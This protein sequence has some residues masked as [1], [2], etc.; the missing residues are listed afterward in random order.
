MNCK[1][2][3]VCSHLPT[4][5]CHA[6]TVLPLDNGKVIVAWFGGSKEGNPDVNI[7]YAIRQKGEFSKPKEVSVSQSLPHWNPVLSKLPDGRI[8]LYFKVGKKIKKWKTYVCYS[9]DEFE[10]VSE[11]VELIKG[12]RS[13]GRGPVKNKC[14]TVT[15]NRII[16]P[17]SSEKHGWKCFVDISDNNGRTWK[18]SKYIKTETAFPI[19]NKDNGFSSNKTKMIQPTLWE[20]E[21][22]NVHMFT[23]TASGKIYRSDSADYGDTWCQAYPTN[24]PNNNSGIDIVKTDNGRLFLVSNPVSE[25]WGERSPLTIQISNDNGKTFSHY[26][27]LEEEKK[28]SEFSYPAITYKS[29][30]LFITYTWERLN[31][32]YCEIEI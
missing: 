29:G 4:V 16:A 24:L 32:A 28:G 31:I 30:K 11:P 6:S 12:D 8:A 7:W 20:S 9:S 17:A 23:R 22:G 25:N 27:T 1:K 10:T 26:L 2:E 13:G 21:P 14:L 18:R 3:Y 19:F 5:N 15:S